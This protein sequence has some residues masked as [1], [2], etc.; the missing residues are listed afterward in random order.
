M[1]LAFERQQLVDHPQIQPL[2][3]ELNEICRMITSFSRSLQ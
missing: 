3:V 1:L 2:L